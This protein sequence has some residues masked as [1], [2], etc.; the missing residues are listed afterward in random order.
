MARWGHWLGASNAGVEQDHQ[1]LPFKEGAAARTLS[2]AAKCESVEGV[3]GVVQ[4]SARPANIPSGPGKVYTHD[5]WQGYGH[6]LGTGNV[7]VGKNK[8]SVPLKQAFLYARSLRL[9]MQKDWEAGRKSGKRP[10]NMPA[11]PD[12]IYS[13]EGWQ[14]WVH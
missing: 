9:K 14:G 2:Y 12:R 11:R 13:H 5:G 1:F 10:D 8:Q 3:E 7:G 4:R 6:S